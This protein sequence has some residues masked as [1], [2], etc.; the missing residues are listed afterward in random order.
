VLTNDQ[1]SAGHALSIDDDLLEIWDVG[2]PGDVSNDE[3]AFV[4]GVGKPGVRGFAEL[5]M[6]TVCYA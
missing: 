2:Y 1:S 3:C 6:Q 4:V 5:T